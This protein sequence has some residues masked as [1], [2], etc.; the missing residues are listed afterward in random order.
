M[1][2]TSESDF[3]MLPTSQVLSTRCKS[4]P[5]ASWDRDRSLNGRDN[6]VAAIS[7]ILQT[8]LA[9]AVSQNQDL[10]YVPRA[11]GLIY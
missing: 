11:L 3:Q 7:K 10:E 8:Q 9:G 6:M 1:S 4:A 5:K 2:S